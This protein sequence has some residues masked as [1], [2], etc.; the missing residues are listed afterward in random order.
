MKCKDCIYYQKTQLKGYDLKPYFGKGY[1][2]DEVSGLVL[3]DEL[4]DIYDCPYNEDWAEADDEANKYCN[5]M[6]KKRE[7]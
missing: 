7:V 1:T 5:N 3:K 4:I 2:F 6:F